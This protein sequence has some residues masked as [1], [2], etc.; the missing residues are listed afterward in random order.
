MLNYVKLP[1]GNSLGALK[2]YNLVTSEGI[3]GGKTG[4]RNASQGLDGARPLVW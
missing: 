4:L 1:E 3:H 2:G